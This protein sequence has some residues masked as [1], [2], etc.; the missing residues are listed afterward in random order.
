MAQPRHAERDGHQRAGAAGTVKRPGRSPCK[1]IKNPQARVQGN[2]GFITD[3]AAFLR[4]TPA[5]RPQ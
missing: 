3:G 4:Q 1:R 5:G 2:R